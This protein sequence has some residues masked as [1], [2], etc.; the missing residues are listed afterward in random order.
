[1]TDIYLSKDKNEIYDIEIAENGDLDLTDGL[2]TS[3]K[4]SVLEERRDE[5][6]DEPSKRNGWWGNQVRSELYELGSLLWTFYQT[7]A[8]SSTEASIQQTILESLQWLLDDNIASNIDVDLVLE[9]SQV[10]ARIDIIRNGSI[11][12]SFFIQL[13]KETRK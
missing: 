5:S 13:F 8:D 3:I 7:R 4:M 6:I 11:I 12:D 10:S 9:G 1:M 2:D